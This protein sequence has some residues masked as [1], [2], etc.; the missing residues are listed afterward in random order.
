MYPIT[1]KLTQFFSIKKILIKNVEQQGKGVKTGIPRFSLSRVKLRRVVKFSN[2]SVAL[3]EF[4]P[5][6]IETSKNDQVR[7]LMSE[8]LFRDYLERY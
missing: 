3:A 6:H 2:T 7:V 1:S 8:G 5:K 4:Q